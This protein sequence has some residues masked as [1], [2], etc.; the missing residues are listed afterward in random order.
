MW[1]YWLVSRV[2]GFRRGHSWWGT[3]LSVRRRGLTSVPFWLSRPPNPRHHVLSTH[4]QDSRAPQYLRAHYILTQIQ[5]LLRI[6]YKKGPTWP[7]NV[8]VK[9]RPGGG[10]QTG[11]DFSLQVKNFHHV[12]SL[13]PTLSQCL[14]NLIPAD[15]DPSAP[16]DLRP[17]H[18]HL[19]LRTVWDPLPDCPQML[20]LDNFIIFVAT[21]FH[22]HKTKYIHFF[23]LIIFIKV[24]IQLSLLFF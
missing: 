23:F 1:Q 16:P 9:G 13:L 3:E 8:M 21:R 17:W 15:K 5:S 19:L 4:L 10:Q 12:S 20:K 22:P 7:G 14:W 6:E 24:W 11:T 18:S 2:W